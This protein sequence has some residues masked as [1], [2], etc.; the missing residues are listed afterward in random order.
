MS[1]P[2]RQTKISL[3]QLMKIRN[4]DII[5]VNTVEEYAALFGCPPICHPLL[6]ICRLSDVKDYI[7][8][9]KPVRLNLYTITIKD[10]TT[11]NANYGWRSYDFTRGCMN[12][13]APGQVHSWEEK[14]VNTGRWGW[15]LAFHPDF[16][17]KYPLG[18]KIERLKFF[19]YD[20]REALHI[21]DMERNVVENILENI[22]NEYR[23]N[24]DAHTQDIIVSQLDVLLNYSERFYTRQ[25]Q[26]RSSVEPDIV[27]RVHLLLQR[28]I[29]ERRKGFISVNTLAS[30]LNMSPHYLSDLL[31]SQTGMN[32]QQHIHAFLIEQAK[33][34]LAT[35]QLSISEIAYRLGFEY[36]Q[37]FN[38]L[39]KSK[40]G[41]TPLEY[42]NKN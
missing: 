36:P 30:E 24:I 21:S 12:F 25:F 16:I 19:S 3:E 28:H 7:P 35:T 32:T 31:R 39:F 18:A 27:T 26:T 1:A 34:L 23:Q 37:H 40:T 14:T 22:E 42:R 33:S 5:P 38:R 6:S 15:M 8:I 41:I 10:K 29:D 4:E 9:G 13:F 17:R 11:C 20:V 2:L